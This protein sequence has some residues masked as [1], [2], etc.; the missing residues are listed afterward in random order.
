[1][2][3]TLTTTAAMATTG[4]AVALAV[5]SAGT[6]AASPHAVVL[7]AALSAS[8]VLATHLAPAL[9]RS[10][11]RLVLWSVWSLCLAG[12]LWAHASFLAATAAE[13]GAARLA[14]SPAAAA[15]AAQRADIERTLEQ[16]KVR[17]AGQILRQLSWTRDDAQRSALQAELAEA[18]RAAHFREQLISLSAGT[19]AA[20]ASV[21]ADPVTSVLADSL[22]VS[23][24]AVQLAVSLLLALL[25]E[26][27]GMLL[28]REVLAT[29]KDAQPVRADMH[30]VAPAAAPQAQTAVQQIVQISVQQPAPAA[31]QHVQHDAPEAVQTVP[32][33]TAHLLS[34]AASDDVTRLRS[35]IARG[36]CLPTV[37]GIRQYLRCGQVRARELRRALESA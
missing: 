21:T 30:P 37:Q 31:A 4:L 7:L 28:W 13:A 9:L 16:I 20:A 3:K 17:P 24:D 23:R 1:M 34:D 19:A 22:A 25:L 29:K 15:R 32:T 10:V 26:V 8:I 11:P 14:S 27:I 6:R 12:A 35:A 18:Q 33:Q 2:Q 5:A 36:D